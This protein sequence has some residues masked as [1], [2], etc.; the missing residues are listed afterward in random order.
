MLKKALK[1]YLTDKKNLLFFLVILLLVA[2][3]FVCLNNFPVGV[4]HDEVDVTLSAKSYWLF[5]T[6]LSGV[7]FPKSLFMTNTWAFL[8]GLPSFLLAPVYGPLT[9]SPF[10]IRI[11]FVILSVITAYLI[12]LLAKTLTG[13]ATFASI[14]I[15][16][17]LINPWLYF[18]SRQPTEAP[19][20]LLFTLIGTILL[21]KH[22]DKKIFYSLP[23]FIA[24]FFSYFGAKP[25]IPVAAVALILIHWKHVNNKAAKWHLLFVLTIILTVIL[26][27]T[28]SLSF[29]DSTLA[30]RE[31]QLTFLNLDRYS[32][33]VNEQ[34]RASIEFPFK[35]LVF[36]KYSELARDSFAKYS[37]SYTPNFLLLRGDGMLTLNEH[38]V[39]YW[40][41]VLFILLALT[42]LVAIKDKKIQLLIAISAAFL[43]TGAVG[44]AISTW[45]DQFVFRNFLQIPSYIM[46]ISLGVYYLIYK[47]VAEKYRFHTV[48]LTCMIFA[49]SLLNFLSI[50][51]FR[52]SV[53]EDRHFVTERVLVKY[54]N[55]VKTSEE[56]ITVTVE[57]TD[58]IFYQYVFYNNLLGS[59][60]STPHYKQEERIVIDN[61]N[62]TQNCEETRGGL[63]IFNRRSECEI[64]EDQDFAVIQDHKDAGFVYYIL[65]DRLCEDIELGNYRRNHYIS[66]YNIESMNAQEFCIR[67]IQN[68]KI[69]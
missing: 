36:N 1:H 65:N 57:E 32:G 2:I 42:Y 66:D 46:L 64:T 37:A 41:D 16:I 50:F 61:I 44:S 27:F 5:G 33:L 17:A 45:P 15:L 11:P 14:T 69:K 8:S 25:V 58:R 10:I 28:V 12:S 9:L 30:Q 55:L 4:L 47:V 52:Y 31:G 7:A 51:F 54:L 34:R 59:F 43:L 35:E 62:F 60:S 22:K 26:Y 19:F 21:F 56:Q 6:D 53:R 29:S 23:F 40:I 68:G 38:G 20:A 48:M 3:R 24:S 63:W 67:W 18:Y 39:L 49:I 13:N